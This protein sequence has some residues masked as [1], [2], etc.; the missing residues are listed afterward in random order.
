MEKTHSK[1]HDTLHPK[2]TKI[3]VGLSLVLLVCVEHI[4]PPPPG[5][6]LIKNDMEVIAV[7]I[8]L[9]MVAI[10]IQMDV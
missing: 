2:H 7:S 5:E 6:S 8:I 3:F 1:L 9:P 10:A 4:C